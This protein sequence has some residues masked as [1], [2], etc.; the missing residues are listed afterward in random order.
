MTKIFIDGS[1]GTTGLKIFDR[2]A[3]REDIELITLPEDLRKKALVSINR[4][5]E[6]G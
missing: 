6:L 2:L 4:M 1:Q 5:L 3:K